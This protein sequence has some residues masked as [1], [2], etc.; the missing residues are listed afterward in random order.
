MRKGAG[1]RGACTVSNCTGPA[2]IITPFVHRDGTDCFA[3]CTAVP[4][5]PGRRQSRKGCGGFIGDH[6][7]G[8]VDVPNL[9]SQKLKLCIQI[10]KE[11]C[12]CLGQK[13]ENVKSSWHR[14]QL[15]ES[16]I[17]PVK[18]EYARELWGGPEWPKAQP[19]APIF[20][21]AIDELHIY[22]FS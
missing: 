19:T 14:Q 2:L 13:V 1:N 15:P 11:C 9:S 16:K 18:F 10:K 4:S 12:S 8:S 22:I 5:V 6:E 20:N 7:G 3:G 17:N 21:L